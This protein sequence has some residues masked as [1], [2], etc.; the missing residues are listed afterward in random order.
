MQSQKGS[1]LKCENYRPTS[2]LSLPSKLLKGVICSLTDNH[3]EKHNLIS[4]HQWGFRKGYSPEMHMLNVT[5]WHPEVSCNNSIG[6]IFL[7]FSKA[8]DSVCHHTLKSKMHASG[9]SGNL[10]DW[11]SNYLSNRTQFTL[12]AGVNSPLMSVVQGVPQ[13][14]LL[15]PRFYSIHSNDMPETTVNGN[16]EMFA[17]DTTAFC[18]SSTMYDLIIKIQNTLTE[19]NDWAKSNGMVIHA[20]KTKIEK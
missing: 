11:C 7:D 4:E 15:G 3:L 6:V 14:S 19:L 17:D 12:I 8:F 2:L 20:G 18:I 16:L 13:G 5:E 10:F 1:R 9:R